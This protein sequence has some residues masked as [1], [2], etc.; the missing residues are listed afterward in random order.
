MRIRRHTLNKIARAVMQSGISN[1]D[2]FVRI[3]PRVLVLVSRQG[4][5]IEWIAL[6]IYRTRKTLPSRLLDEFLL[7]DLNDVIDTLKDYNAKTG[8]L[9]YRPLS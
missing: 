9:A 7:Y 1:D 5:P 8:E 4:Y 6:R 3:S 2:F